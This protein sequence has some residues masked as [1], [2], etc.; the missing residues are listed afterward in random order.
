MHMAL[1]T[2]TLGGTPWV[3][4]VQVA[5]EGRD[6]F[7]WASPPT[8]R[9]SRNLLANPQVALVVIDPTNTVDPAGAV[10]CDAWAEQCP[11]ADVDHGLRVLSTRSTTHD[12][13]ALD[14]AMVTG[15][16]RLRLYRARASVL[17]RGTD[18]DNRKETS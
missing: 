4:P 15:E 18:N 6:T 12:G 10:S 14:A 3:T 17:D 11:D 5:V 13:R 9:H 7:W 2:A 16:A 1:A 8:A